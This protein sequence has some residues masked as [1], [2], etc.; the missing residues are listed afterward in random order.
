LPAE[1]VGDVATLW[2]YHQLGHRLRPV[3]VI[4]GLG[5]HDLSVAVHAAELW[6][7]RVAP[8]IVFTGA[9]VPTTV[10]QFPR[11]EAVHYREHALE[12]GIPDKAILIEPR[13]TNTSENLIFSRELLAEHGIAA[14]SVV[15]VSRPYQQRRAYASCRKVW[16]EVDV[17]CSAVPTAIND[18]VAFIGDPDRVVNMLVGD[19]QRICGCRQRLPHPCARHRPQGP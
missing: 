1:T 11:G 17:I 6:R 15:L 16:P 3:D 14:G 12:L 5:G 2:D 9:T 19:T 4:I 7:Q 8:L 10:D 13:A 18:Y